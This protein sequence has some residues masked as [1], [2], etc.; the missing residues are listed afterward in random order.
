MFNI[1]NLST[2]VLIAMTEDETLDP[3]SFMAVMN[4][5]EYRALQGHSLTAFQFLVGYRPINDDV[6]TQEEHKNDD[7][8]QEY[9]AIG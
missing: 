6:T 8:E 3:I 2:L 5:L 1:R 9:S 4:E 7:D